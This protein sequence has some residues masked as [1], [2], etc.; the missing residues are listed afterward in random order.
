MSSF[1]AH[2]VCYSD[3]CLEHLS[4][5]VACPS[6]GGITAAAPRAQMQAA[7]LRAQKPRSMYRVYTSNTPKSSGASLE[8]LITP[9]TQSHK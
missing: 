8:V 4:P 3:T 6:A 2:K 7:L 5:T 9:V 1:W